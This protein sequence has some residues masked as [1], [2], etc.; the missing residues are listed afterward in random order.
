M[1]EPLSIVATVDLCIKWGAI[2]VEKCSAFA[3]AEAEVTDSLLRIRNCWIRTKSQ[4]Q[5]VQRLA[6]TLDDDHRKIH[7]ET[8][9]MLVGKLRTTVHLIESI[10][11]DEGVRR[12]KYARLQTKIK[13]TID[14]LENWQRLFDP[15]WYLLMVAA[16]PQ[17]D[18]YLKDYEQT[19][20]PA[21]R[22]PISSA[23]RLRSVRHTKTVKQPPIFYK[24]SDTASLIIH[25][26]PMSPARL[27]LRGDPSK[28]LI[29]DS[30]IYP[31]DMIGR[32]QIEKDVRDLAR[33]LVQA[34]PFEFGLLQCK[35]VVKHSNDGSSIPPSFTF[36]FRL[37]P[38]CSQP[39]SLRHCLVNVQRPDSLSD[40]FRLASELAKS[41][42]Y[43]H[44]FGFVHKN[45][46]PDTVLVLK[47][48]DTALGSVFLVGF[49]TFRSEYGHTALMGSTKWQ[50]SLYQHPSRIGDHVTQNYL[51][52]HDIY[53]L[54]VCLLELGLWDSFV[55]YNENV[56]DATS[57]LI[58]SPDPPEFKDRLL[59]LTRGELKSRMGDL[60][61]QVVETC[62]TSLDPGNADFGDKS[63][64]QDAD[65]IQ[66]GVRYI[67][68]I[69][70][71]LNSISV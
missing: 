25:D 30:R 62:L 27:G 39:R 17:I 40:R 68:K 2:L 18:D 63:E 71:R 44:T 31:S 47:R 19:A 8:L 20:T 51:V 41:V 53:S 29:L 67:E 37:P 34:D 7:Y 58:G 23:R 6:D 3:H 52:Q 24:E 14:D 59:D 43:V 69:T 36:I 15:S 32:S 5:L 13:K 21:T 11:S 35:G 16:A 60:Y 48:R 38:G 65:G 66:V 49:D 9:E 55:V 42:L 45:I 12:I 22:V 57:P 50:R 56:S 28:T 70:M 1:V 26:I 33:K 54:G 4:L 64:F 61:S 10:S 46:R